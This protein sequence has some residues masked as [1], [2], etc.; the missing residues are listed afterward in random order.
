M[1]LHNCFDKLHLFAGVTTVLPFCDMDGLQL[2][3]VALTIHSSLAVDEG[4]H[5]AQRIV[6]QIRK[7]RVDGGQAQTETARRVQQQP[8]QFGAA[9]VV[10]RS[11]ACP[12]DNQTMNFFCFF[13]QLANSN[14]TKETKGILG[15]LMFYKPNA[16]DLIIF[17]LKFQLNQEND[18]KAFSEWSSFRIIGWPKTNACP[19]SSL[20]FCWPFC[21]PS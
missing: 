4:R 20:L 16:N 3:I 17:G 5:R 18:D 15:N 8:R 10:G 11:A 21:W 12:K 6:E 13:K 9:F 14:E 2:A 19:S 7:E 1:F